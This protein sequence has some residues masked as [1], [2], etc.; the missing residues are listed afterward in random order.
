M[1]WPGTA[2]CTG[3]SSIAYMHI[4]SLDESAARLKVVADQFKISMQHMPMFVWIEKHRRS[5]D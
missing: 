5:P 2:I 4:I 3:E 1:G